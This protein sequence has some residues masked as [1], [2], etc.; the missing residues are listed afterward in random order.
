MTVSQ[1]TIFST[2]LVVAITLACSVLLAGSAAAEIYQC[3]LK[4]GRVEVRDFPCDVLTR[5]E[6]P[7]S[8]QAPQQITRPNQSNSPSSGSLPGFATAA[9]YET[10]KGICVRL[11]SQYDFTAPLMRC[12]LGDSNCFRRANQESSAIFQ[13]LT[14]L[15]EWKRQQC[16]LVLQIE[17]A[18]AN[19]DQKTFEVV[20]AVRGCKYFVAEQG[21]S[22]SLIEEWLCIRPSQ[23]DMGYGDISNY[24]MK[25]VKLNGMACTVYVDDWSLGRSRATEKLQQKCR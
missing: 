21:S 11:M 13:R 20:G 25:E 18:A 10:A 14:A 7:I 9:Q 3:K 2:R 15:P 17:G 19:A 1:S 24:G 6:A 8:Q 5:P 4:D 12:G 16:D 23:G 22:Y